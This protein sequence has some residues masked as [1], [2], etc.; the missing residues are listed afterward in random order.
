MPAADEIETPEN[1]WGNM[2]HEQAPTITKPVGFSGKRR[3]PGRV[4]RTDSAA[5]ATSQHPHRSS[6][7]GG[8]PDRESPDTGSPA[9]KNMYG[10]DSASREG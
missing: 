8:H 3:T 4:N 10:F 7:Q 5:L 6:R 9:G 2:L 1:R